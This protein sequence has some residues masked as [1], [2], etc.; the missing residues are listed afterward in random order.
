MCDIINLNNKREREQ[1]SHL[2]E[3]KY[4]YLVDRAY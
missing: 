4:K 1:K 3:Y 2:T